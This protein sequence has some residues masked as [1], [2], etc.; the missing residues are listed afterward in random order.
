ML[1]EELESF[2]S[3][4]KNLAVLEGIQAKNVSA[5]E[6]VKT[7]LDKTTVSNEQTYGFIKK[8][9]KQEKL[10]GLNK[11]EQRYFVETG[12][13][14]ELINLAYKLVLAN[15]IPVL[16]SIKKS[17]FDQVVYDFSQARI[18]ELEKELLLWQT[19]NLPDDDEDEKLNDGN[20]KIERQDFRFTGLPQVNQ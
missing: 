12:V 20:Q 10:E 8:I 6:K 11:E 1:V 5:H 4:S 14:A 9:T 15:E 7:E 18:Q 13:G 16:K 3:I 2:N 17:R 19:I